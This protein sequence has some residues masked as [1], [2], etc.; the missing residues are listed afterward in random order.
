MILYQEQGRSKFYIGWYGVCK[1]DGTPDASD[2]DTP[3]QT[4]DL[5]TS[6]Y[7]DG[8]FMEWSNGKGAFREQLNRIVQLRDDGAA[9][10]NYS[11]DVIRN[12]RDFYTQ[13]GFNTETSIA[14]ADIAVANPPNDSI[15]FDQMICGKAYTIIVMAGTGG[16]ATGS[17]VSQIDIPEFRYMYVGD[18]DTG[19]RLTS[20][21]CY[22]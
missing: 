17:V 9:Y 6:R 10:A 14:Q 3:C 5:P 8:T 20:E 16:G 13:L 4:I 1:E 12:L 22:T 18:A 2:S 21:C 15:E 7:A 11:M 19:L